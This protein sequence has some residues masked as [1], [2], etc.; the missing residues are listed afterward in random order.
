MVRNMFCRGRGSGAVVSS[1]SLERGCRWSGTGSA[2]GCDN[3]RCNFPKDLPK[4]S[5][6]F[7]QKPRPQL[8]LSHPVY[9]GNCNYQGKLFVYS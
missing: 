9:H 1:F 5:P 3:S 7:I 2:E 6:N 8:E 4:R